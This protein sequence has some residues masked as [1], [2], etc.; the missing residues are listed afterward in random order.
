MA[1]LDPRDLIAPT[2]RLRVAINTGNHA[3]V[4][5]DGDQ[6]AGVS[7]ALARRLAEVLDLRA[8]FR[9]Y[10]GA[11]SVVQAV[12]D[13]DI[14]FLA[15]EPAREG[16]VAFT[17]PYVRIEG[18]YA[19]LDGGPIGSLPDVDQPGRSVMLAT[20]A[21]YD[22]ALTRMLRHATIL[23]ADTPG[24]SIDR[25]L[26]GEGDAVAAVRQTLE[27]RLAGLPGV[28]ILPEPFLT[29][30]QAMAVPRPNARALPWLDDFLR[31]A[32][33]EGFVREALDRSGQGG[34]TVAP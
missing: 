14:A 27:T 26:A 12:A 24:L 30:G 19:V 25:W 15:V 7:P 33:A 1:S 5:R 22:H 21:A 3:L 29:I 20:G 4:Q 11:G 6:L 18:C 9:I 8:E 32:K 17:A 23:R 2:G 31:R 13:W 10:P 16:T 28:H 34:L